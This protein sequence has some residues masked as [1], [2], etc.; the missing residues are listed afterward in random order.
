MRAAARWV[1]GSAALIL[2]VTRTGSG[3]TWTNHGPTHKAIK[4]VSI[5]PQ[6]SSVIFAG[7]F[8][9]G[10]FKS[11]NAGASWTNSR[12]GL[13]NTY[14]RSLAAL[15]SSVVFCGTND[16]VSK[17][18]DG[19]AAWSTSLSTP[20][21]V[22]S[23]AYDNATNSLYA[24]SFGS[25]MFKSTNQGAS[26]TSI[27]VTDP[28]VM[29]TLS[30]QWSVAL[31]GHDSLYAGGT[32]ADVTTGGALFRSLD[33]GA[34]WIQVQRDIH[35]PSS[36]HSISINPLAPAF[37]L[38]VGTATHGVYRTTN[39]GLNWLNTNDTSSVQKLPDLNINAVA[40]NTNYRY[41]GTDSLGE[42]YVRSTNDAV[43]GWTAGT[44]LPGSG[45]VVSSIEINR[46]NRSTVFAGTEGE[47]VYRSTNSGFGWS[48]RN[49][50]M[51]G[52]AARVIKR[53]GDG[54][55]IL[56][57]DFGDGIWISTD[58]GNNWSRAALTT[59]NAITSIAI[60][61]NS[62]LLY[63]GAFGSGVYKSNDAGAS[64]TVT[65]TTTHN[66]LVRAI[67]VDPTNANIVF[68][69]TDHSVYKT[70]N[71]G[72]SWQSV[73]SGIPSTASI[74]SLAV[75]P[76]SPGTVYAGTDSLFLYKSTDG[77]A[78][79][80]HYTSSN[81]FIPT[82]RFIRTITVDYQSGNI[83]YAGS[84]SGRI[85]KS[86]TGGTSWVL[87]AKLS[88][89]SSVRSILIH[90]NDHN[91]FFACTFGDGVFVSNDSGGNWNAMSTGLA[92]LD[93]YTLESDHGSPLTVYA[94]SSDVGVY[95]TSYTFVNHPPKIAPIGTQSGI[96][97]NLL[98]FTVSATDP[99][100][101][102]PSLSATGL[103]SGA[104]FTDSLNGRGLFKW[105]PSAGQ[106]GG[107][108]VTFHASDGSLADS[109][110]VSI[111][112]HDSTASQVS[113]SV[114]A[115]WN[116]LSVP[117]VVD[118]FRKTGL[119]PQAI[120]RAFAYSGGY[121]IKDTLRVGP[122]YWVKFASPGN[123]SMVGASVARET[124]AVQSGWNLIGS[125]SHTIP[126]SS[127]VPIAPVIRTSA[128]LGYNGV[129]GYFIADSIRPAAGYWLRVSQNGNVVLS[130]GPTAVP[131]APREAA[132][133]QGEA[134]ESLIGAITFT[135]RA[136]RS[137]RL[138]IFSS[139]GISHRIP[140]F[141]LPPVPPDG[142]FDARFLLTQ[143]SA[144][145]IDRG[146]GREAFPIAISGPGGDLTISW[147]LTDPRLDAAL[148]LVEDGR[149]R[150]LRLKGRGSEVLRIGEE[151]IRAIL[152]ARIG[153]RDD[154]EKP[155][156]VV[157]NQNYPNPFNPSTTIE[158]FLPAADRVK[159]TI[160]GVLGNAV[161][162]VVNSSQEAGFHS[163]V[164]EASR[165]S[166]GV[167]YYRLETT[168]ESRTRTMFLIR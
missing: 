129:A 78:S 45:S 62:S 143:S 83:L 104:S 133:I 92:D 66:P 97:N 19:G 25:G 38:I 159:L 123:V 113:R 148:A 155:E 146:G 111:Y 79:W 75:D 125:L 63:A 158:Y 16:G 58:Q 131:Q 144:A 18:T 80:S 72:A 116:L 154:R 138:T 86:T 48:G 6:D 85:Y 15:S 94:G 95:S 103:P 41:A 28:L 52:T 102:I 109:Q 107:H 1:C 139:R 77:G 67:A 132:E 22:R 164:W 30:H 114:E 14:V 74:R 59:V 100:A 136:G 56:G 37:S 4:A 69:G 68:A 130:S 106:V 7:A 141:D 71:G 134:E 149:P 24:A 53:N 64:W 161:A 108:L 168:R 137:R 128:F 65:D 2:L 13:V 153:E 91:T 142:E 47:G 120:S 101:T 54:H 20:F 105:T 140:L 89:T 119:F 166:S 57:T 118:D 127:A 9:W 12:V 31:F 17:S 33:G 160:F 21:S 70:T 34:S 110:A 51:L 50:G 135:D 151:P 39:G 96:Q 82:D 46:I 84:D 150:N 11:T 167:Y 49:S 115:G 117:L 162:E 90:P 98:S 76:G 5:S 152:F 55:L 40:Y 29:Q 61:G 32:L 42:L 60:T 88:A 35:I 126:I 43:P 27:S 122:A 3:Q 26:W 145:V 157:L 81:G 44:G 87:R 124:V 165:M 23:L 99:D 10:V 163:I 147:N 36:V 73:S 93:I 112:I 121:L 8:G 156:G